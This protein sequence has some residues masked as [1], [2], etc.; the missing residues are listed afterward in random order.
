MLKEK[1]DKEKGDSLSATQRME[2]LVEKTLK[3]EYSALEARCE[4]QRQE[5]LSLNQQHHELQTLL[6][7][8]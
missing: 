7:A 2:K 1:E 4:Q 5:I 8:Q 6:N 3:E